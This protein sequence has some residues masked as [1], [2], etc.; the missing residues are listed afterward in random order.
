MKVWRPRW[1]LVFS[2]GGLAACAPSRASSEGPRSLDETG[3]EVRDSAPISL[4]DGTLSSDWRMSTIKNQP[5]RDDPGR[6]T[7]EDGVLVAHPGTDLGLLWNTR[8]TP[9][10]FLLELEW[11]LSGPD[12]NSGVFVRFPDLDS[13]GYDNTAWV[14]IHFGFEV[15]INEPGVPDG[16]P[17]HTTGAIYA[18]TDQT[19]TRVVA[20]PPGTWNA[21]AI[22]VVGSVYTVTLNGQA[23]TWF[24]NPIESR[25]VPSRPGAPSFV[26]LQTHTG[27]VAYRNIRIRAL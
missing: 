8:P 6:F 5:G 9:P 1:L 10:D 7:V 23:V 22:R 12:D 17:H 2:L 25:G 14:A 26:G 4:F 16:A 18:E 27:N 21:F 20:R 24:E 3:D 13:K 19:F 11:K 15:Q